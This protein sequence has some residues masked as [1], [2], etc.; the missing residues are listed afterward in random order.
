M[1]SSNF[2]NI[3][4]CLLL[5]ND[6]NSHDTKY[7]WKNIEGRLTTNKAEQTLVEGQKSKEK[8]ININNIRRTN[9]NKKLILNGKGMCNLNL[10]KSKL[11]RI[12]SFIKNLTNVNVVHFGTNEIIT[13]SADIYEIHKICHLYLESNNLLTISDDIYKLAHITRIDLYKNNLVVLP[14]EICK[15]E[16][17]EVLLLNDNNLIMLPDGI[18]ELRKLQ[19]LDIKSNNLVA[20]PNTILDLASIEIFDASYNCIFSIPF[21]KPAWLKLTGNP[22]SSKTRNKKAKY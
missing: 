19:E 6:T 3:A 10:S 22:I 7:L 18:K 1:L 4:T 2:K 20:L 5:N 8:C 14:T 9:I 12:P 17:L 13:L 15:L 16:Y 11:K 21:K